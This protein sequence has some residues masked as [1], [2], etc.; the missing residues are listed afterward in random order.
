MRDRD[1]D[2]PAARAD[3]G[4]AHRIL[5]LTC[6]R[7]RPLHEHLGVRVRHEHGGCHLEIQAHELL[8][9]SQIG[10]RLALGPP[11]DQGSVLVQLAG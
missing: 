10:H 7:D 5:R 1:R 11:R 8:V 6:D 3:V 9:A 4:D 2:A